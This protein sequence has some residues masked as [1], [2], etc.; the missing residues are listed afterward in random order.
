M[1]T[2]EGGE[3]GDPLVP[4]LFSLEQHTALVA[5]NVELQEENGSW[6]SWTTS[7]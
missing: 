6:H 1:W 4:M 7:T 3:Q 5:V 2:S